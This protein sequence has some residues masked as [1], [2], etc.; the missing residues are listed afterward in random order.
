MKKLLFVFTLCLCTIGVSWGEDVTIYLHDFGTVD[1]TSHPY[2]VPPSTFATHLSNSSW[3]NSKS[4]WTSYNGQSG[5]AIAMSSVSGTQTINLTFDIETGYQVSIS[6][7]N[8]W[9]QRSNTGPTGWSMTINN[10][11]VGSG[12]NPTTGA[13]LATD[14]I[15]VSNGVNGQTGSINVQITLTG[16]T[17]GTFRLDNFQLVGSVTTLGQSAPTT[18]A[19]NITFSRVE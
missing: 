10:I 15:D 8:F 16:G 5:K 1:I 4:A 3:S 6:K 17:G 11:N 14:P 7:Y 2:T 18:Q 12:T 13:A 9:R 19:S